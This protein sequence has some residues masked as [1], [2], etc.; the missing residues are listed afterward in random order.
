MH[1]DT[2]FIVDDDTSVR[3]SLSLLFSLRGYA[4]A[5]F[6]NAEEFLGALRPDWRGCVVTDLQM[7]GM[8][9]IELQARL[10][11]RSPRL[12]GLAGRQTT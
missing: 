12:C 11:R 3:D 6:G 1:R 10:M 7:P 8:S 4:T 2:V 9:G 5:T